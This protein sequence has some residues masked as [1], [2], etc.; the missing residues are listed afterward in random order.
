METT[1]TVSSSG[2]NMRPFTASLPMALLQARE[3]TMR[4]F[5]PM[6][7]EYDLT[8]QQWRVLRALAAA[9]APIS[10]SEVAKQTF[11]LAPSLSR[12]VVNLA[13]RGLIER[14][15]AATD[16]RKSQLALSPAGIDLVRTV[17]PSSEAAY[18]RI[19]DEFGAGRLAALLVELQ[20]LALLDIGAGTTPAN[21]AEKG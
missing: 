3:A 20:D 19:E 7:A 11:L 16:Q 15:P 13:D 21:S 1:T 6:L 10:I 4:L 17:G 14:S 5:R 8:E 12:M 18:S 9:K 2:I